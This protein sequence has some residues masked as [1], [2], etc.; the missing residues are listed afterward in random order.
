MH[1]AHR[2]LESKYK[3]VMTDL[4][5]AQKNIKMLNEKLQEKTDEVTQLKTI[6]AEHETQINQDK[7]EIDSLKRE[8]MIKSRKISKDEMDMKRVQDEY[9]VISAPRDNTWA[10]QGGAVFLY[11]I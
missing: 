4:S 3:R 2:D 10:N 6:K 1:S 9:L 11:K 5:N 8:L 7:E